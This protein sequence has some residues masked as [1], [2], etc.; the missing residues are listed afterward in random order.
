MVRIVLILVLVVLQAVFGPPE[1]LLGSD[2]YWARA[3]SYSF[4]HANWW[5][6]AVNSLAIWAVYKRPGKKVVRDLAVP[7]VIAVLVYPLSFRPVIGFSNVLYA[8]IGLRTPSLKS[9]WWT[10]TNVIIFLAVTLLMVFIPRFSATTHIAAFVL[11]MAGS[12]V[13]RLWA[14]LTRD[15]RRYL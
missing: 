3:L 11:G 5:H 8:A 13:S 9:R 12:S 4:F 1:Y 2:Q 6:L 7:F 14:Y 10:Q 15:A